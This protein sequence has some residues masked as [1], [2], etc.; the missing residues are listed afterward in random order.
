MNRFKLHH[1]LSFALV[2]SCLAAVSSDALP[3]RRAVR[4]PSTGPT[5]QIELNATVLDN[6]TGAP[7][8]AAVVEAGTHSRA[9]NTSGKVT[10]KELEG[11]FGELKV[12]VSRSGYVAQSLTLTTGGKHDITVRL[13]PT[14]TVRV[15]KIDNTTFDLDFES[16]EFGYPIPFSGYRAAEFEDFCKP[17][18]TAVT[19]NRSQI[20]R[21][22]GPA[23]TVKFAP[24]CP[25]DV[26]TVKVNVTLKTGETTDLYFVDA[27]NGFPKIDVIGREH[28]NAKFQYIAFAEIAE[29][30]FP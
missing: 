28:V 18:G 6:V 15:R 19:I 8:V 9:T 11:L 14:P 7:V 29:V 2:V 5:L 1:L 17:D 25:G 3:R 16:L 26:D 12:T 30:I 23:T 27:C 10:I 22:T 13:Q 24:C 4:H 20:A 21:I